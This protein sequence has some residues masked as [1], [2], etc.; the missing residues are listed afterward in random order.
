M[1]IYQIRHH[2]PKM[3]A[4]VSNFSNTSKQAPILKALTPYKW[5]EIK[6]HCGGVPKVQLFVDGKFKDSETD[7]WIPVHNPVLLIWEE[8]CVGHSGDSLIGATKH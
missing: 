3:T 4:P 1:L 6:E 8:S 7:L 2:L 5:D